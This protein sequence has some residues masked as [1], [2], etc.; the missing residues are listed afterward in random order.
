MNAD[1]FNSGGLV[2]SLPKS[3]KKAEKIH[4]VLP[5]VLFNLCSPFSGALF[6]VLLKLIYKIIISLYM[7]NKITLM[8]ACYTNPEILQKKFQLIQP[9][10]RKDSY[11]SS[12]F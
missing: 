4:I 11:R 9:K 8:N 12:F 7:F 1:C 6:Y 2:N 10:V 5:F 3:H